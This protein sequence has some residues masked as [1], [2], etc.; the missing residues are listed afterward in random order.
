VIHAAPAPS[1]TEVDC[2]PDEAVLDA[3][4]RAGVDAPYSCAGGACG[5]CVAILRSGRQPAL[6]LGV[7]GDEPQLPP[8]VRL[9]HPV[10]DRAGGR[11]VV[12]RVAH[13]DET[14]PVGHELPGHGPGHPAAQPEE[15]RRETGDGDADHLGVGT[16]RVTDDVEDGGLV[17]DRGALGGHGQDPGSVV[18]HALDGSEHGDRFPPRDPS[19]PRCGAT[20]VPPRKSHL[21]VRDRRNAAAG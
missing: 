11:P 20:A 4:L 18:G 15:L 21:P 19:A 9:P 6:Q 3:A 2:R 16:E 10:L 1:S 5:T 8:P 7:I 13:D 14:E 17:A 12:R